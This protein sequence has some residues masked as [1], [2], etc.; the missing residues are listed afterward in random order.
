MEDK[1]EVLY[2]CARELFAVKGYRNTSVSDITGHAGYAVGTFYR[3]YASKDM[4]FFIIFQRE[5]EAM[6]KSILAS[7]DMSDE[8]SSLIKR[9]LVLNMEG[10]RANPIL[11]QWYQPDVFSRIETMYRNENG[12]D[13]MEFLYRDFLTLV[14]A[15][16]ADGKMRSDIDS[17]MI[18][19]IFSA[20]IRIGFHKEEIG[21]AY[22]P[23][24]Q[25]HLTDFVLCGLTDMEAKRIDTS[26]KP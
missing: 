17:E 5:T 11:R 26:G 2:D 23:A 25:E 19:A 12:L 13:M 7:L 15:W 1:R 14:R 8:P 3:Y 4:L 6:M 22:F 21:L 16:Q 10:M 9:L 20:I 18:M 24:L